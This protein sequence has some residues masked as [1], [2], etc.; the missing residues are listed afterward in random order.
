M[1]TYSPLHIKASTKLHGMDLRQNLSC[2]IVIILFRTL[3][4][5]IYHS[6]L[7]THTHA[8]LDR[9]VMLKQIKTKVQWIDSKLTVPR[10]SQKKKR[11]KSVQKNYSRHFEFS[12]NSTKNSLLLLGTITAQ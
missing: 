9:R 8:V 5:L 11:G 7:H 10:L 1:T 3:K 6:P 4:I 2:F 12:L